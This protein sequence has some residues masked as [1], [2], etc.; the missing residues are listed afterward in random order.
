[1]LAAILLFFPLTLALADARADLRIKTKETEDRYKVFTLAND[2]ETPIKATV[3]LTKKCS[4][5]SNGEKSKK[6]EYWIQADSEIELG[7]AWSQSTCKRDYRVVAA[8]YIR[9]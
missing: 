4:G 9:S 8:E 5:V 7:R 3:E 2:G 6:T 1:L